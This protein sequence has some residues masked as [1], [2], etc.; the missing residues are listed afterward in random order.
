MI[1]LH[2]DLQPQFK[3]MN[4]FIYTSHQR[5]VCN[6]LASTLIHGCD[7]SVCMSALFTQPPLSLIFLSENALRPLLKVNC[8]CRFY[9]FQRA[10]RSDATIKIKLDHIAFEI[11][12][13]S[14]RM[15]LYHF[16]LVDNFRNHRI[17]II[18]ASVIYRLSGRK[19][20]L[21]HRNITAW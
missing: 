10:K 9:L 6:K 19:A 7:V 20:N 13:F 5:E 4:Y 3:Y 15:K 1:I 12:F 17:S 2:F 16:C 18:N 8:I 11:V 14:D 21:V